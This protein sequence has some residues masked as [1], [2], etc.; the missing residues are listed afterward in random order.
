[1]NNAEKENIV[2]SL[3][4]LAIGYREKNEAENILLAKINLNVKKGEFICI[5]GPNGCGKSTLL[6]TISGIQ[7]PLSGGI[8]LDGK[9]LSGLERADVAKMISIALTENIAM[10]NISVH[11]LVSMGRYPYSHWLGILRNE[12]YKIIDRALEVTGMARYKNKNFDEL[13]DGLKQKAVIARALAQDTPIIL[14]DEPTAFLDITSKLEIM[15]MLRT[16]ASKFNK[17]IILSSHDLDLALQSADTIWLI[18]HDGYICVDVPEDL[19]LKG[20]FEAAFN[21]NDIK[22]QIEKG[23]FR[24]EHSGE[25]RLKIAGSGAETF[26]T[27]R[28]LDRL[29]ILRDDSFEGNGSLSIE[30]RGDK[31][32]W[33]LEKKSEI[34][35]F[36]SVA[37]LLNFLKLN[38]VRNNNGTENNR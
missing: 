3:K 8:E 23:I 27:E 16:L 5:L 18:T 35:E 4:D 7:K 34:K 31:T 26:W 22:F 6:R 19:V 14:F 21:R 10:G 29:G 13:S 25:A 28:A 33:L 17:S 1:M 11:S 12:D 30:K 15:Q 2:L 24:F 20:H 38:I 9:K 37:A 32:V 36:Y